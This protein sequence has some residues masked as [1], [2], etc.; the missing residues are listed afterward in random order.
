MTPVALAASRRQWEDVKDL[1][2]RNANLEAKDNYGMT[3]IA[4]AAA[5]SSCRS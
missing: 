4:W 2:A 1:A 5:E 3:F